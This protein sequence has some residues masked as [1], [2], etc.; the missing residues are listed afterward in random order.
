MRCA[1]GRKQAEVPT[2]PLVCQLLSEAAL[3]HL[4]T[5]PIS[6]L[7]LYSLAEYM[8]MPHASAP[9]PSAAQLALLFAA[10]HTVNDFGFYWTHRL[11]H[12]KLLYARVHKQHH[13]FRGSVGAAAEFA[14]PLEDILSN[15]LPTVGLLLAV[16]S[17]PLA[18]AVWL[19][20]RLTQS[21]HPV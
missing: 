2:R 4:V 6:A 12:T 19:V 1:I 18:Q 7:L 9:L 15:Q 21:A 17:H 3:N 20:L 8:G 16:G 10:A 5:S 14:S 13:Q 11:L